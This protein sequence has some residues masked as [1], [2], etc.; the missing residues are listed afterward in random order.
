[1]QYISFFFF[2]C[3]FVRNV[4]SRFNEERYRSCWAERRNFR[5]WQ[6]QETVENFRVNGITLALVT[7]LYSRDYI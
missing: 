6:Q 4:F 2:V 3:M 1:M 7:K 5:K